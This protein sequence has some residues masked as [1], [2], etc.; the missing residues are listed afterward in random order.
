MYALDN[1]QK[2]ISDKPLPKHENCLPIL[3]ENVYLNLNNSAK[4]ND[5][6]KKAVA[7]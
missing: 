3:F 4:T 6:S 1:V 2:N 5:L 7:K